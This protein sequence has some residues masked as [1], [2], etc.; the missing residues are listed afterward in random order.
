[1]S[2]IERSNLEHELAG[3]GEKGGGTTMR[4]NQVVAAWCGAGEKTFVEHWVFRDDEKSKEERRGR[5]DFVVCRS[6]GKKKYAKLLPR[7][8]NPD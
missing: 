5:Q 1:V 4:G 2:S 7:Q 6:L 3:A 8:L